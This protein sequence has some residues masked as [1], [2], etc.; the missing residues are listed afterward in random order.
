MHTFLWRKAKEPE[1]DNKIVLPLLLATHRIIDET[2][3]KNALGSNLPKLRCSNT[4]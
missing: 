3:H 2:I 1:A 4:G